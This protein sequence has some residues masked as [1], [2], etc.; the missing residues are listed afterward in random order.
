MA[1]KRRKKKSADDTG[2][3]VPDAQGLPA[4]FEPLWKCR[5]S[6]RGFLQSHRRAPTRGKEIVIPYSQLKDPQKRAGWESYLEQCFSDRRFFV[7][8][9]LKIRTVDKTI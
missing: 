9:H 5:S 6:S 1:S 7:E 8:D 2:K 3:P 4:K